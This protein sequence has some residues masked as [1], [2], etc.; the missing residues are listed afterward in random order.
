MDEQE[1]ALSKE[2]SLLLIVVILF[3]LKFRQTSS[4]TFRMDSAVLVL[5]RNLPRHHAKSH[6]IIN[7]YIFTLFLKISK[8]KRFYFNVGE[9]VPINI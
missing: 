9:R 5:I 8:Y 7:I 4:T 6:A 1:L 2:N 3:L